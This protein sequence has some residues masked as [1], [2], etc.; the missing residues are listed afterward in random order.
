M[1]KQ[2]LKKKFGKMRAMATKLKEDSICGCR[3]RQVFQLLKLL[4]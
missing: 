1:I 4:D 2:Y 3:Q